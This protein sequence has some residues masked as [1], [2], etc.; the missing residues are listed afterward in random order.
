MPKRHKLDQF[1]EA[2]KK[3]LHLFQQGKSIR[4]IAEQISIEFPVEVSKSSIHRL[5]KRYEGVLKAAEVEVAGSE[6]DLM[7]HS[8]ALT[9]IANAMAYEVLAEWQEKGE[10]TG[11][12][13]KALLD[14]LSTTSSVAKTTAQIEKIKTQLIQH[15]EKLMEKIT[16]AVERVVTDENMRIKLLIE[17][18]KELEV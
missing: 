12:K 5:I 6:T 11:E 17:I 3:A 16:R 9:K 15:A 1:P 8:Q 18:R 7:A 4:E 10:I 14:L 13:F 2:K